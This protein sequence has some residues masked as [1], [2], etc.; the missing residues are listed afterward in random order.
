MIKALMAQTL[1]KM[2]ASTSITAQGKRKIDFTT[3]VTRRAEEQRAEG[4]DRQDMKGKTI[5]VQ[6]WT[7]QGD[8]ASDVEGKAGAE[9]K[10]LRLDGRS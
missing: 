3:R 2:I 6:G 1:G 7:P 5:G 4:R 8:D 9:V 10:L